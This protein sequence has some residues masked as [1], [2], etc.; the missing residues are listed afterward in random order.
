[1]NDILRSETMQ[2]ARALDPSTSGLTCI[3][4]KSVRSGALR[5]FASLHFAGWRVRIHGIAVL[6]SQG[7]RWAQLPARPVLDR[8]GNAIR[9]DG[10]KVVYAPVIEFDADE[11]RRLFSELAITAI[12]IYAPGAFGETSS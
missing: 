5:G 6:E 7:R 12:E 1:M 8:D 9:G 11:R 2:G 4:F 10:G 3:G